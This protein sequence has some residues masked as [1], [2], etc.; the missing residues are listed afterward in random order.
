[1][2]RPLSAQSLRAST[3]TPGSVFFPI[4][5]LQQPPTSICSLQRA[6]RLC[7]GRNSIRM[8]HMSMSRSPR[9]TQLHGGKK[10]IFCFATPQSCWGGPEDSEAQRVGKDAGLNGSYVSSGYSCLRWSTDPFPQRRPNWLAA[11]HTDRTPW[12]S[13]RVWP[14]DR[15][16]Q[17]WPQHIAPQ[18]RDA[19]QQLS[20][21][22]A[23]DASLGVMLFA[24]TLS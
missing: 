9:H 16:N 11:L 15:P 7:R 22:A 5:S 23:H 3:C 8:V 14:A 19:A 20:I 21:K 6:R 4:L 24:S 13:S 1:M 17:R 18:D 10:L 2:S 12:W